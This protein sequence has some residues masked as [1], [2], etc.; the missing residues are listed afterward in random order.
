MFFILFF[1]ISLSRSYI[2]FFLSYFFFLPLLL[3]RFYI[4]YRPLYLFVIIIIRFAYYNLFASE[5]TFYLQMFVFISSTRGFFSLLF[6][7]YFPFLFLLLDFYFYRISGENLI[8]FQVC[9]STLSLI[10][11]EKQATVPML[12]E[13]NIQDM[14]IG[15]LST[16]LRLEAPFS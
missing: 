9:I 2:R 3:S 7:F 12:L 10:G 4:S 5:F 14:L 6:V 13:I 1:C 8:A 16:L 15:F 11:I